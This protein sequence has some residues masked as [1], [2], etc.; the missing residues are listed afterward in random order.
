MEKSPV[1]GTPLE[2]SSIKNPAVNDGAM[3]AAPERLVNESAKRR[4]RVAQTVLRLGCVEQ[5]RP[6]SDSEE[7][8]PKAVVFKEAL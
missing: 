5:L 2:D 1:N 8:R 7:T 4:N 3:T 6:P